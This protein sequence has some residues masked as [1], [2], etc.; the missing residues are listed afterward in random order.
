VCALG[1]KPISASYRRIENLFRGKLA[2]ASAWMLVG[3]MAAGVLG[4]A[5]QVLMGRMLSVHEYALF[6]AVMALFTILATP[7]STMV[8]LISRKVSECRANKANG[9]ITYIYYAIHKRGVAA[10]VLILGIC[11]PLA[12]EVQYYLNAPNITPVY[13]LGILLFL[14]GFPFINNAF[15]QG[16]QKFSWLSTSSALNSIFKIC[17]SAAFVWVGYGVSGAIGGSA[18]AYFLTWLVTY[19]VLRKSLEKG[20]GQPSNARK[21]TFSSA[22]PIFFANGAFALM[23]Q[24]DMLLVNYFFPAHEA[25]L[26][27]AASILGKAVL[28]LPG[29]I[30]LA[31]FPMVAENH[32][33]DEESSH[34]LLQALG[35]T[36]I[37]C[38][39][40]ATLY[41]L[42]GEWF[43]QLM[44]GEKYREAG[45]LLRFYGFSILPM[46]IVMVMEYYLI[47]KGRVLFA[48]LF[49][50]IAPLQVVAVYYFHASLFSIIAI[51]AIFGVLVVIIGLALLWRAFQTG[52]R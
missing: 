13:L 42:G 23:T 18:L 21:L 36:L 26:Y 4:Y 50:L 45:K 20:Q 5:L 47:A 35:L 30:A 12:S 11:F 43:V 22:L 39:I 49:M 27:A 25:G 19:W 52:R 9:S 3:S 28:Y 16:L 46:S 31:L 41:F 38:G 7:L 37:L 10:G 15:L 34:L 40:G 8:M 2:N 14:T 6:S 51:M 1:D 48:Y 44:Y 17:I 33:R 24:L 32:A 29:G